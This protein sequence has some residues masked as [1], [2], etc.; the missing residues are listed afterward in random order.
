VHSSGPDEY[1]ALG[2]RP[3]LIGDHGESGLH[4]QGYATSGHSLHLLCCSCWLPGFRGTSPLGPGSVLAGSALWAGDVCIHLQW[5][6]RST[7]AEQEHRR[8]R[9]EMP[10]SLEINR[11]YPDVSA[12][13]FSALLADIVADLVVEAC[14]HAVA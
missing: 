10:Q 9:E 5:A 11:V 1:G 13:G 3:A 4:L 7:A 14:V 12:L 8:G 2:L 6:L